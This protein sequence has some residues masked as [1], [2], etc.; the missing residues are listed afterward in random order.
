[1]HSFTRER[2]YLNARKV[3]MV[4]INPTMERIL[5]AI[6]KAL[7]GLFSFG[8]EVRAFTSYKEK[9]KYVY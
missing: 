2:A 5:P 6:E 7:S 8:L 4:T 1:M 9:Y 3:I